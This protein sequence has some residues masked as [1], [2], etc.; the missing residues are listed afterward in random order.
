MQEPCLLDAFSFVPI[1]PPM[2]ILPG[3]IVYPGKRL[4]FGVC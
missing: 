3:S 1:W 2:L 4:G